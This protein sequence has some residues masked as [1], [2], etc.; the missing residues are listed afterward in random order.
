MFQ[1]T[2]I[3]LVLLGLSAAVDRTLM[4][5]AQK[6]KPKTHNATNAHQV[7]IVGNA[8]TQALSRRAPA[9]NPKGS[10]ESLAD[11]T[12]DDCVE[13]ED[14]DVCTKC[15]NGYGLTYGVEGATCTHCESD[16][17][18]QDCASCSGQPGAMMCTR[19]Q[20]DATDCKACGFDDCEFCAVN[21]AGSDQC[22]K[23]H[24]GFALDIDDEH[25]CVHE[26][27]HGLT[28]CLEFKD[29]NG[30]PVCTRCKHGAQDCLACGIDH[31]KF[32]NEHADGS[33]QCEMCHAGFALNIGTYDCV[34]ESSSAA[35]TNCLKFEVTSAGEHE[36]TECKH[37][38]QLTAEGQ[39]DDCPGG[40]LGGHPGGHLGGR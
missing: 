5:R 40:H 36:C 8:E 12:V 13:C 11:C 39:C 7:S 31:C 19:C 6:D 24:D 32:C 4:R 29:I 1:R 38:C 35:L 23:C 28:D 20:L 37:G 26:D 3:L 17:Q 21:S 34:D 9:V 14:V 2:F 22:E 27:D 25:K 18:L 33:H 15:L 16:H 30:V 10:Q